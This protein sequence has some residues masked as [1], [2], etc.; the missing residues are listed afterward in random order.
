MQTKSDPYVHEE[1]KDLDRTICDTKCAKNQDL[2]INIKSVH[3]KKNIAWFD[4]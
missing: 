4:H 1:K 2:T 3:E